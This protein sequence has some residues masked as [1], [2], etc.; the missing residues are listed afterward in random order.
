MRAQR[1]K[2]VLLNVM[3]WIAVATIILSVLFVCYV[4]LC[5]ALPIVLV[6]GLFMGLAFAGYYTVCIAQEKK[7]GKTPRDYTEKNIYIRKEK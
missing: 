5:I 6:L 1:F 2:E 3:T 7:S 4:F